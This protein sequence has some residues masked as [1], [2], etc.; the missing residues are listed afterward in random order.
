MASSKSETERI[1]ENWLS[2]VGLGYAIQNFQMAGI[3]SPR[4]MAE[5]KID[6]F[7]A[8]G[9]K[10]PE[11]RKRLF[12]LVQK[13]KAE[14]GNSGD[15]D[16]GE[17]H[18]EEGDDDGDETSAGHTIPPPNLS[19]N[20]DEDYSETF[21][22]NT[23]SRKGSSLHSRGSIR[24]AG[25]CKYG[26]NMAKASKCP[27]PST[28]SNLKCNT[29][30]DVVMS[31]DTTDNM[32]PISP[33]TLSSPLSTEVG[34]KSNGNVLETD[35]DRGQRQHRY[36]QQRSDFGHANYNC[37][38]SHDYSF[39]EESSNKV[40]VDEL[41]EVLADSG[42]SLNSIKSKDRTAASSKASSSS[43]RYGTNS[44]SRAIDLNEDNELDNVLG[45][46]EEF[47]RNITTPKTVTTTRRSFSSRPTVK[48]DN[49][50]K[51]R[52][53]SNAKAAPAEI[54]DDQSVRSDT[55]DLSSSVYSYSS[56]SARL[57]NGTRASTGT[58]SSVRSGVSINR[59][60][61]NSS[62]RNVGSRLKSSSHSKISN[63]DATSSITRRKRLSTIPS[64]TIAP[65][66]P[67]A[68]LSS[69]QLDE[70]MKSGIPRNNAALTTRRTSIGSKS[71]CARPGSADAKVSK[72]TRSKQ[73]DLNMSL[74]SASSERS[75]S[76]TSSRANTGLHRSKEN[77][78]VKVIG[79]VG[80]INTLSRPS[81][82]CSLDSSKR[83]LTTGQKKLKSPARTNLT[84]SGN[85][86]KELP[87]RN[88]NSP[89]SQ[90]PLSPIRLPATARSLSP[91][92]S[93]RGQLSSP[94]RSAHE[95][96]ISPV[97]GKRATSPNRQP[98]ERSRSPVNRS[99]TPKS[100]RR[101]CKTPPRSGAVYVHGAPEDNSWGTQ[102]SK[103][104]ESFDQEHDDYMTGRRSYQ[105]DE[106]YEMRIRVV[107]RKRPMSK[108]EALERGEADVIHPLDYDEYGRILVYQ[109][110]TKLDLTK[111]VETTS[112]AF[113]N[114]FDEHSSN[115]Q[116]YSRAVRNLIPG[117]FCGK[118]ASVFAY[119][120]TGS[121][122]TFTMMGCNMTG[123]RAGNQSE[124]I[125]E[126]NLGLYFLA[127]QDVFRMADE[128]EY[129]NISIGVSLFEIYG[130]KLLDL[131]NRRR[132]IKCLEDSKGKVN[133]PG[134]S[135]HP[136]GSAEE[137]MDIIEAGA[138][139]RST[140]TTSANADS[141][142]SHAVLQLS[143]RKDIGRIKHKEH[144]RLTFIDLA[145]SERGADTSQACRTTRMEGAE[146]NTS[147]LS[148]KEVIRALATG[149][150][151]KRIPFRGSKLTQV[152]KESF[153]GKNSRTVMVA[154]V[155]P[156][157]KN[158]D[159]TLNTLRYT[160]RVKERNPITGK[161]TTTVANNSK[162]KRD[163]A[164]KTRPKL[165]KLPPRPLTAPATS[166]RVDD[167]SESSEGDDV[168]PPPS[169]HN[170]TKRSIDANGNFVRHED[171]IISLT[172]KDDV[173]D[174]ES[175]N[176]S[177]D[178]VLNSTDH[179]KENID[180]QSFNVKDTPEAKSLIETHK[181][182]MTK[183]LSMVRDEMILVTTTDANRDNIEEYLQK[184]E[185]LSS[186][187]LGLIATL[188]EVSQVDV[189]FL[190]YALLISVSFLLHQKCSLS[191]ISISGM[192][193]PL[194]PIK[195]FHTSLT[196]V[197]T[198]LTI[199]SVHKWL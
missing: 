21:T 188:K 110:K 133:F 155:A 193:S 28:R 88:C 141:S 49:I 135:E 187:Q 176:D 184:L 82:R 128:P 85:R 196:T 129:E 67:I 69:S 40:D 138:S 167:D 89:R 139:N 121:G 86:F 142:R 192:Q 124:S 112:F 125:S 199:S 71:T 96:S 53:Y 8:L 147:L 174:V 73:V 101:D 29:D 116:I 100:P 18:D 38:R 157:M 13:V 169:K 114:V 52:R 191:R 22:A 11:D 182:I 74:N 20:E 51:T 27:Y 153:V 131:L 109:P 55:S 91:P 37:K 183:M 31:V 75:V 42:G 59:V 45:F 46:D 19:D 61:E 134:L 107:V 47:Q 148:L 56:A 106:D 120:Q 78:T 185:E 14:V 115:L 198:I 132:P 105:E 171:D 95:I 2:Q 81:S 170:F 12:F 150:S 163:K 137:L 99:V 32:E 41:D 84:R 39:D 111:E 166:F 9:V 122:K 15:W 68:G 92:R 181:N 145:G 173:V 158:C 4:S 62:N 144:G 26:K 103:L 123:S 36:I 164:E 1:V 152:L 90:R 177:L 66:S 54:D 30:P 136:V 159:H 178:D 151:M 119:G 165:P 130:G 77:V 195:N 83:T 16:E 146:I 43:R 102:I 143:L 117:V 149:S 64:Q 10:K 23:A 118:W 50:T 65:I 57:R 97:S 63:T 98:R 194:I 48:K 140:G 197:S 93:P 79:G 17:H 179:E 34:S 70:S 162:I 168:P 72:A 186:E 25:A 60:D 126:E 5:L 24:L 6:Y 58:H 76:S 80:G 180:V 160:D 161:L 104:R 33:V 156:N 35:L 44:R 87:S 108:L 154:C 113:D 175:L 190:S 94:V 127:A 7:E 189:F 172:S 3:V